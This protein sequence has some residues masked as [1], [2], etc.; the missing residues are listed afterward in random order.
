[1]AAAMPYGRPSLSTEAYASILAYILESN[2]AVACT[3]ELSA[4]TIVPIGSV[5]ATGVTPP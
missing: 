2:G 4:T 1:M 3:Q 5:T